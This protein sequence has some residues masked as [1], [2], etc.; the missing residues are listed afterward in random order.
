MSQLNNILTIDVEESFH[1]NDLLLS[2]GQRELLGGRLVEQTERLVSLLKAYGQR[3]TF[4]VLGEVAKE[5]PQLVMRFVEEGFELGIHGY[6]HE[7]VYEQERE[8]FRHQTRKAKALLEEMV[9][10]EIV[11]FRAPSWSITERSLWALKILADVGFQYDSSILPARAYLGGIPW[12]NTR[13]HRREEAEI[14]EVPPSIIKIG[15][16]RLPFSGGLYLRILPY[17][18]IQ[19]CIKKL[20]KKGIPAVIYLH[21]WELDP[22]LPR[23]RLKWKGRFALYHNLNTV[24]AKVERLLREFSFAPIQEVLKDAGSFRGP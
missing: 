2:T 1:R 13:I 7:L 5:Y 10:K 23:L 16:L 9:G 8:E 17:S 24:Q 11:G 3:G 12:S 22:E 19:F 15:R 21:P 4:F 14:I 18:F 20:N 6:H